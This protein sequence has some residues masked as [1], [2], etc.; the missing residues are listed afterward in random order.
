MKMKTLIAVAVAGAFAVPFAAQASVENDRIIVAQASGAAGSAGGAASGAPGSSS[1]GAAATS[2]QGSASGT[3]P[4]GSAVGG[5]PSGGSTGGTGP[6]TPPTDLQQLDANNDGYISRDEASRHQGFGSR[7]S[8][9]DKDSDG[10]ISKS[11]WDAGMSSSAGTGATSGQARSET[12]ASDTP[13][14]GGA[15]SSP[16]K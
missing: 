12:R 13:A 16:T 10:R 1:G 4:S 3:S 11:E 2:G 5:S 8:E 7:F 15:S 6:S 14:S 9:L